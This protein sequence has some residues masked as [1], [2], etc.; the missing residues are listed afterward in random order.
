M[1]GVYKIA[2]HLVQFDTLYQDT[3]DLCRDYACTG[4]AEFVVSTAQSDI[5][6]ERAES[7]RMRIMEG[8]GQDFDYSDGYLETLAVYRKLCNR[9][10]N[11]D[12]LLIHGSCIAVDDY[13]ILF[14]ALSGTG[15][16]THTRNWRKLFG[17][18]VF[19]VNDDKPLL[20]VAT[21]QV[22]GTPWDGKHHLST[23]INVPLRHIVLLNRAPENS[24]EPIP[25]KD[26]LNRMMTHVYMPSVPL[27]KVATFQLLGRLMDKCKFHSLGCN[28]D[29]D[30]ARVALQ[31]LELKPV[32]HI[33]V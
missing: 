23:N 31:G 6:F 15:K 1:T 8:H 16:S 14:V 20:N 33:P 26:A 17:S 27:L 12:I 32:I 13:G 4:N 21:M 29:I 3:H 9:L 5:D 22:Y 25:A 28:K 7:L 19:M 30:S 11:H 10:I 24:I 2:D 18:R